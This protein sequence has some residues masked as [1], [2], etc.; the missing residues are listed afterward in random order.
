[1]EGIQTLFY[2]ASITLIP[3]PDKDTTHKR[4]NYRLISP[5]NKKATILNKIQTKQIEDHIKKRSFIGTKMA[6]FQRCSRGSMYINSI[7]VIYHINRLRDRHNMI[8]SL[9]TEKVFDKIQCPSLTRG[10][11][12]LGTEGP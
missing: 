11:E 3:K 10:I 9:D 12:M 1:M 2:E 7:N 6:L 4:E 5:V 8:I